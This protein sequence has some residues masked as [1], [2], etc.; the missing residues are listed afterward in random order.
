MLV[1][2]QESVD[3]EHP[4]ENIMVRPLDFQSE[5]LGEE[6]VLWSESSPYAAMFL[7][8]FSVHV[9]YFE[10]YLIRSMIKARKLIKDDSLREDVDAIIGQ[11]AHHAR[12]FIEFNKIMARRFPKIG[13]MEKRNKQDFARWAKK[14]DMKELV[15]FT[16]GYETFTFLAGM[17]VLANYEGWMGDSEETMKAMWV[18]HQVEE[19]EHGAVAFEVF[20][21]LYGKYEWYR[22]AMI[23]KAL[24]HIASEVAKA[25][26]HMCKEEGYFHRLGSTVKSVS[27][28]TSTLSK[29]AW[30][31]LPTLS[32]KYHPREHPLATTN[33]N[34]IAVAWRRFTKAGGDPLKIDRVKM[35]EII[36][37]S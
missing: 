10:R 2:K 17:I 18:W 29:M 11:E 9:P 23:V 34:R 30:Y 3:F 37:F 31:C 20:K 26:L 5:K 25:Y 8:A 14:D 15:G 1:D 22:K 35:E 27:F 36:G 33:Q 21:Y 6:S 19:V 32:R 24:F 16:A 7:N 28:L 13:E 12:N 4:M